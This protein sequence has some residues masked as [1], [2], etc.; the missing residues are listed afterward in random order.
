[1]PESGTPLES[2]R[3]MDTLYQH[4]E[5]MDTKDWGAFR[6]VLADEIDIDYSTHR[7]GQVF[8]TSADEWTAHVARRLSRLTATQH[9]VSNPRVEV[10]GATARATAYIRAEHVLGRGAEQRRYTIGGRYLDRLVLDGDRWLLT[11]VTLDA[12]WYDGDRS[13]LELPP[14]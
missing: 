14:E 9:C 7:P 13:V 1:M 3:V 6:G 2:A 5:A 10:A 4:A 11:A 12:W 8:T